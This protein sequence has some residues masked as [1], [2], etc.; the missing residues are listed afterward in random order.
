MDHLNRMKRQRRYSNSIRNKY[1]YFLLEVSESLVLVLW[2]SLAYHISAGNKM[3][4]KRN[5]L[6]G[7]WSV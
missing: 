6:G 4:Q 5:S 7:S 1:F 2:R 3:Q